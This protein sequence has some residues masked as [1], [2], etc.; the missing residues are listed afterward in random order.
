VHR[1]VIV[2]TFD[3]LSGKTEK[4]ETGGLSEIKKPVECDLPTGASSTRIPSH[5]RE[6]PK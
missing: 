2:L 3:R 5:L 4:F 1:V 6:S